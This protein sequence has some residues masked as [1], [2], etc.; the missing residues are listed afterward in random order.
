MDISSLYIFSKKTDAPDVQNGYRYQLLKTLETWLGNKAKNIDE[1]IYCD[2]DEDIFQ[3]NA[4]LHKAKFRQLKLYSST[5][6]FSSTEVK[7]C[8]AHFFMLYVKAD[9]LFD[10]VEFI[11]ETNSFIKEDYPGNRAALLR[12]WVDEQDGPSDALLQECAEVIKAILSEYVEGQSAKLS[13]KTELKSDLQKAKTVF[14]NLTDDDFKLFVS[15]IKWKFLNITPDAAI[16]QTIENIKSLLLALPYPVTSQ[17]I[18]M[19]IGRLHLE[20]FNRSTAKQK[21]EK[22]VDNALLDKILLNIGPED[23][24][25]YNEIYV[26]WDDGA[27]ISFF[28]TGEFFEIIHAIEYCRY[29]KYLTGHD[30]VWKKILLSYINLNNIPRQFM[31]KAIYELCLLN[32]RIDEETYLPVGNLFNLEPYIDEY[33]KDFDFGVTELHDVIALLTICEASVK[34]QLSNLKADFISQ[35]KTQFEQFFKDSLGQVKEPNERCLLLDMETRYEFS[36]KLKDK[37]VFLARFDEIIALLPRAKQYDISSLYDQLNQYLK[38]MIKVMPNNWEASAEHL[39]E[40]ITRLE[41]FVIEKDGNYKI[42]KKLIEE[43]AL[44]LDKNDLKFLLKAHHKFHIAT[45]YYNNDSY[46]E[47]YVLGLLKIAQLYVAA[48]MNL[49]AKH[50]ALSVIWFS[51]GKGK[52]QLYKRIVDAFAILVIV[53][54]TQ[55]AWMSAV[56]GFRR[57]LQFRYEFKDKEFDVSKDS[58]LDK[59]LTALAF[60]FGVAPKLVPELT[61]YLTQESKNLGWIWDDYLSERVTYLIESFPTI[62]AIMGILEPQIDD[63]PLNDVGTTRTIAWKAFGCNWSI[64]FENDYDSNAVAEEFCVVLQIMQIEMNDRKYDF[65]FLKSPIQIKLEKGDSGIIPEQLPSNEV[66]IWKVVLPVFETTG[67]LTIK[68]AYNNLARIISV[69]LSEASVLKPLDFLDLFKTFFKESGIEDKTLIVHG[70][71]R[72]YREFFAKDDFEAEKRKTF[73]VADS[74]LAVPR[75]NAILQWRSDLSEKYN[76]AVSKEHIVNRYRNTLPHFN[77]TLE[78]NKNQIDFNLLIR[79]LRKQGWID[80]HICLGLSSFVTSYRANEI[81]NKEEFGSEEAKVLAFREQFGILY[82]ATELTSHI[83]IPVDDIVNQLPLYLDDVP[84][85]VLASWGLSGNNDFPNFNGVRE[86]LNRRFNFSHDDVPDVD[87]LIDIGRELSLNELNRLILSFQ[88]FEPGNSSVG[89]YAFTF[90]NHLMAWDFINY[91]EEANK[92]KVV[93]FE[94]EYTSDDRADLTISDVDGSGE[95]MLKGVY[96]SP[97]FIQKIKDYEQLHNAPSGALVAAIPHQGEIPLLIFGQSKQ[98]IT[99][100][101]IYL[102]KK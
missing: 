54:F 79:S 29:R 74:Q 4:N 31:R 46:I 40:I 52:D 80:W 84:S 12:K 88:L 57:Y 28:N 73:R 27:T 67:T 89:V 43:G 44:Y 36:S 100:K 76:P 11:F 34:T 24:K 78:R 64:E 19:S 16:E 92:S 69:I 13:G 95:V 53:D 14:D 60:I 32:L 94:I 33:F 45:N 23:D 9:Y 49:A 1:T 96:I 38:I 18:T 83:P 93:D 8:I 51:F 87:P 37:E 6:S 26:K 102:T 20:I 48:G 77:L 21:E 85:E 25:I 99:L 47:G 75:E 41:P 50:Y 55:G 30:A 10:E 101:T 86:L 82:N 35:K 90:N 7:K 71:Q 5:F 15:K 91:L 22:K 98:P 61:G 62:E 17:D 65:H 66:L 68:E 3:H 2:Y 58:Q 42:A 56:A 59:T 63:Q 81:V 97:N 39:E 72:L 70:Y